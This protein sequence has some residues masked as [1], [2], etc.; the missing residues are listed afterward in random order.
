[1]SRLAVEA[2]RLGSRAVGTFARAGGRTSGGA[3]R[4]SRSVFVGSLAGVTASGA[5]WVATSWNKPIVAEEPPLSDVAQLERRIADLEVAAGAGTH[6]AF[7]FIKP[8]AVC[9]KVKDLARDTFKKQGISV[10][11]EGTI[12]AE[13]IDK[14]QLIDTHYGAIAA[15][16]VK[17]KPATLT[18]QP[19]AQEEFEKAFGLSWKD[20]LN[21][22][23]VFNAADGAAKLGISANELGAKYD[24][25]KKGVTMLKFGGG[26]YCGKVDGIFVINGFYMNMR[27]KFTEPGTCIHYYEVEWNPRQL[28][29]ADFRGK[30][31]G[32]TDPRTA[33]VGSLRN[34]IYQRWTYLGLSSAPDTGDNGVHASASPFEAMAERANWLGV[35]VSKDFFGRA[36][37][38]C[39]VPH[40]TLCDWCND[41][42]VNFDGKKQSLFD[43]LEDLDGRECLNKSAR[44]VEANA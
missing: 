2:R 27:A 12:L 36:M 23:L 3:E 18:V 32:G 22:G 24:Q 35:P 31:L 8:H 13:T 21:K 11:S 29:W 20:A 38:S 5:A 26:F 43:L 40:H 4:C 39:G 42:T 14:Q 15:K 10:V 34:E 25:L 28:S 9:E 19:K 17:L 37:L 6:T 33:E 1:M 16:A 30:V 44:I 41:P 7:V